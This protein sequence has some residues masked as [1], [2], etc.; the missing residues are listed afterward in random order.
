MPYIDLPGSA[1]KRGFRLSRA[2]ANRPYREWTD[3]G[4]QQPSMDAGY[5]PVDDKRAKR[6]AAIVVQ[7]WYRRQLLKF[8]TFGPVIFTRRDGKLADFGSLSFLGGTRIAYYIRISDTTSSAM[9]SHFLEKYWRLPRPDVLISVTGSAASLQLTSQL[10]RVFDRGLASAAAM[11]NAWIFTG[12][13]DSGVMKLV[14]E[15]MHK[16]GLVDVPVVGVAPWGAIAGRKELSDKKGQTIEVMAW[17]YEC[18]SACASE[19]VQLPASS[20]DVRQDRDGHC[21]PP[22]PLPHASDPRGRAG[23]RERGHRLGLG[24]RAEI[25]PRAHVRDHSDRWPLMTSDCLPHQVC[26]LEGR[27]RSA[28]RHPGRPGNARHVHRFR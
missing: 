8:A 24:D 27:A 6:E 26:D 20:G 11:T 2:A 13:T 5:S 19:C 21:R 16:Y 14:G 25:A 7:R 22:Q 12:G 28:A 15:A 4:P 10:Q 23:R 9:L 18:A 3:E 17:Q 1:M